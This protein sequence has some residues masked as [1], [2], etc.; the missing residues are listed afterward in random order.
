MIDTTWTP[1]LIAID[2]DGTLL[3]SHGQVSER[4]L[5]ALRAAEAAGL[6][7][8]IAT[9]RRHC[10]A[11]HVL[12]GLGLNQDH[13]VVSSNGTVIRT[14]GSEVRHRTHMSL[15]TARWLCG[16]VD[17]FR[18]TLVLTFDMV[19]PDGEDTRGALVCEGLEELQ[20]SINRWMISNEPYMLKLDRIEDA[21]DEATPGHRP[22]Q[23]MLCGPLE[24]M[25]RAEA[26]LTGHPKVSA[27]GEEAGQETE[28]SLHR[29]SY[30]GKDLSIV[31]ILPAGCS[32][33]SAV[34]RLAE[35]RGC[36]AADMLAIGDN[37]NDL[38]MLRAAGRA[39]LMANAPEELKLLAQ[40]QGWVVAP[41]NDE[42][43]VAVAIE[44]ALR[45]EL[46][47]A[48]HIGTVASKATPMLL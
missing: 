38:P 37:W 34:S 25:A 39:V 36:T 30:P 24:R 7:P 9:G 12:R 11:M 19:Q 29:T 31:D 21:L 13:A 43:G 16:H 32:K 28:I 44:A 48:S 20:G 1:R 27:V 45:G 6:E 15:E 42:D 35:L 47:A 23:A 18:N 46:H 2:M 26:W 3:N 8:V 22:I 10:Y 4:N 14:I 41:S 17:E 33:A 5:A 40:E